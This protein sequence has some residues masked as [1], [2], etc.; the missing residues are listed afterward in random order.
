MF[1]MKKNEFFDINKLPKG[2]GIT[3]VGISMPLIG[4][5]QSP[6]ECL[7]ATRHLVS[8]IKESG[9]GA[10]ILYT[11]G[12]YL[13]SKHKASSLKTKFQKEIEDHKSGYLKLIKRDINLVHKAFS[14]ISW[15][16]LLLDCQRFG[17]Y[18]IKIKKIYAKDKIFQKYVREDILGNGKKV[19]ED[20]INY[21]L[22]EVLVDYLITKMKVR[23]Q[24]D[25]VGDKQK[26]ILNCYH[27]KPHRAHVYLYQKDFFKLK[28]GNKYENSWYDLKARKLYDFDN[29]D[30]D[31]FDFSD[32]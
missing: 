15:S 14:F 30:I 2:F 5:R 28:C 16:Q 22:E 20:H 18:L 32:K 12:L 29:L 1:V 21:I 25:F 27:G 11:D 8:K 10:V 6:K 7:K 24:N 3:V 4:N 23:L 17:E 9:T 26:W 13:N 19:N 31:I